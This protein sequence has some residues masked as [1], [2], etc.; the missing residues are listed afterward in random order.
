[1]R[2]VS[3]I[4]LVTVPFFLISQS[5]IKDVPD[6]WKFVQRERTLTPWDAP[7]VT[8]KELDAVKKICLTVLPIE[9]KDEYAYL[10]DCQIGRI[11]P[12]YRWIGDSSPAFYFVEATYKGKSVA[13]LYVTSTIQ[14]NFSKPPMIFWQDEA[15]KRAYSLVT[16]YWREE[17]RLGAVWM[18]RKNL[19]YHIFH[20]PNFKESREY[21]WTIPVLR[22]DLLLGFV[23]VDPWTGITH[24]WNLAVPVGKEGMNK[25]QA[26]AIGWGYVQIFKLHETY[27]DLQP[28]TDA[29]F[30]EK[31]Q[32]WSIGFSSKI[33]TSPIK[34][35]PKFPYAYRGTSIGIRLSKYGELIYV[36]VTDPSIEWFVIK[37]LK[38][39]KD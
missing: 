20:S 38:K 8:E 27:N 10:K 33:I 17:V 2:C 39:P 3:L 9:A 32:A 37:G 5:Q 16:K 1:M 31:E 13:S 29:F 26:K 19:I 30:W 12:V 4:I 24:I 18:T 6:P 22:G 36:Y 35:D 21:L 28:P 15:I 34:D 11:I 25:E 7:I 14:L 23:C